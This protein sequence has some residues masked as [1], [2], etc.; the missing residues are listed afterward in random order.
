MVSSD[1]SNA[2][3][4]S[5]GLEEFVKLQTRI[6]KMNPKVNDDFTIDWLIVSPLI[7]IHNITLNVGDADLN[8]EETHYGVDPVGYFRRIPSAVRAYDLI[9][10]NSNAIG[11][12][13]PNPTSEATKFH[14]LAKTNGSSYQ[15][16]SDHSYFDVSNLVIALWLKLPATSGGDGIQTIIEKTGSFLIQ[17]DA[18][19]TASNQIRCRS[20]V[21]SSNKDVTFTYTPDTLFCLIV[22][23]NSTS[24]EA[25]VNNVSQGSISTGGVYD[26]TSNNV[27]I[28]GTPSGTQ[29]MKSGCCL[30]WLTLGDKNVDSTWR[31]NF[32]A[33]IL[34]YETSSSEE[35]TT[36]PYMGSVEAIPNS[37]AGFFY[38]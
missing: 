10:N 19:A 18:H 34:D 2:V 15:I 37:H 38:G 29:L 6:Q 12:T 13:F 35:I 17:I 26:P 31:T 25:F 27:G 4:S 20:I 32:Q 16:I 11:I 1:I 28:F 14:A 33:G 36:I 8:H 24:V 22:K 9:H 23:I 3:S 30:A 5:L 21:S 7:D